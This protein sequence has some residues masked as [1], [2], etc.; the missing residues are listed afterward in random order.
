MEEVKKT[1]ISLPGSNEILYLS[2]IAEVK[3]GY[4]DPPASMV[5]SSGAKALGIAISMREGGNNIALG[6][7][8]NETLERIK[9]S[10]PYGV[11]FDVVNFSPTEVENKVNSFAT[12]LVQADRKSVV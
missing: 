11:E 6:E 10:Y 3:R 9:N 1:V 4:V 5:H 7:K 2:D 8:V 12:N